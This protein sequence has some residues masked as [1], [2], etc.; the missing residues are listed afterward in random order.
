MKLQISPGIRK[1]LLLP[2]V[3]LGA[4]AFLL[5]S[6][7]NVELK[8]SPVTETTRTLRVISV[9][10]ADFVPKVLGFG[11]AR[12]EKVWKAVA[13]V[14]GN[15]V[16]VSEDLKSGEFVKAGKTLLKVDRTE[17]ELN[18]AQLQADLDRVTNQLDELDIQEQNSKAA[19]EIEERSLALAQDDVKRLQNLVANN[20]AAAADLDNSRRNL[21]KQ[22]QIVENHKSS[23]RLLP[24]QRKT[25]TQLVNAQQARLTNATLDVE[26]TVIT[27]PFDCRLG[28]VEIETG[29]YL[30]LGQVIFEADGTDATEVE[31]QVAVET[32]MNLLDPGKADLARMM[33]AITSQDPVRVR[34]LFPI[35][36][37]V[38]ARAGNREVS[39]KA[40]FNTTTSQVDRKTRTVG[41]L[42]VVEDPYR[43]IIPAVR[44]P[45][46]R[47][48]FCE[49]EL[50][51]QKRTGQILI[52]RLAIHNEHVYI[53]NSKSR[54]E[55][56]KVDVQLVQSD[57]AILKGGLKAGET[58]VVSDPT[59][60]IEGL[61]VNPVPDEAL[62]K[63]LLA[64]AG[65]QDEETR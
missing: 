12:P 16:E 61:L 15:V 11:T 41:F 33:A 55:R 2:P 9:P 18:V 23:L 45:L 49:V 27:A 58:L 14:K 10:E 25:T 1:W 29:Q 28:A 5:L 19:L 22:E 62:L 56:R 44:P 24:S 63:S 4:T 53:V 46:I 21:L 52:P 8:Q 47:G 57:L 37:I 17:Y 40:R 6:L 7:R 60:A 43:K 34:E 36:A 32:A 38:R 13:E 31:A 35:E 51:G 30:Q 20:A 39:W 65:G 54:L 50:R 64:D 48:V 3:L 42:V 26:K 59:P